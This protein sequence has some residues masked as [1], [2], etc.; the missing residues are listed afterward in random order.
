MGLLSFG[1]ASAPVKLWNT[2]MAPPLYTA[3]LTLTDAAGHVL[4]TMTV[5]IGV[6]SAVF[7]ARVGFVLN[8][9]PTRLKGVL[10]LGL[11]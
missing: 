10:G 9:V 5:R 11:I 8:G 3:T 1:S 7:D 2:A 6:R 4:D